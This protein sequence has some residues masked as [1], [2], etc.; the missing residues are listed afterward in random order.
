MVAYNKISPR[1]TDADFSKIESTGI[2]QSKK[3]KLAT[4]YFFLDRAFCATILT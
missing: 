3:Q 4:T 1:W 2:A